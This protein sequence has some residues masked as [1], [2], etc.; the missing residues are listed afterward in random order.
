MAKREK[1][2]KIKY[3][4][5]IYPG[6]D[7]VSQRRRARCNPKRR[8]IKFRSIPDDNIVLLLGHRFKGESY[9]SVHPPLDELVER[10]DPIKDIVEPTPGARAGDRIRFIQFADSVYYPPMAPWLRPRVYFARLRGVDT[11]VYSG[12]QLLE[13]RERDLE[14]AAKMIIESEMFDP[15]RTGIRGITV[16]G[17]SLRL[18][19]D[20]LM[21][22][23]RR[24]YVL[25]KETGEVMYTKNQ[26]AE[27]LDNPIS[28][29]RPLTER[30]ARGHDVTYRWDVAPYKSRTEVLM[31]LGRYAANRILTGFNPELTLPEFEDLPPGFE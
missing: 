21:F 19:E 7:R 10:Y 11:M 28:V 27:V 4:P 12:R 22:D 17:H 29:G 3:K 26:H 13:M 18:D 20:G 6:P 16:H 24:R 31:I 25:D 15:A 14:V 1:K 23:A 5:Q 9:V 8:L 30:E 2:K